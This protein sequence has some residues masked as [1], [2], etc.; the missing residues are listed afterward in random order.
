MNRCNIIDYLA[1]TLKAPEQCVVYF[2]LD[3]NEL[4]QNAEFVVRSLL[5]Q[6]AFQLSGRTELPPEPVKSAYD[7]FSLQGNNIYPNIRDFSEIFIACAKLCRTPVYVLLDGYD[8][9]EYK[10]QLT[11]TLIRFIESGFVKVYITTRTQLREIQWPL[12]PT[13]LKI[14]TPDIEVDRFIRANIESKNYHPDLEEKIV[15]AVTQ[16]AKGM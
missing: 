6:L 2:Y 8:K 14:E 3:Q 10:N 12:Q 1:R 16:N 11:S 7:R 9:Y 15:K 4:N 13:H 5:K